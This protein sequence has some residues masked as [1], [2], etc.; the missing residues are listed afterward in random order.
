MRTLQ[1]E[2]YAKINLGLRVLSKRPDGYHEIDTVLQSVD[3][4]DLLTLWARPDGKVVLEMEPELGIP[5][6][7]NLAYRAAQSLKGRAGLAQG[8]RIRIE[9]RVPAGAG[10][11]GGSSDAAAVLAGLNAL[12]ALGLSVHELMALGAGLGSDVPFFLL[13]GR[14]RARGR[15]ERLEKLPDAAVEREMY[16]LLVP[17]FALG[18][19]EVYQTFDQLHPSQALSSPYP[20]DLEAAALALRPELKIYRRFLQ[21]QGVPFGMSGSGPTYF[22][23]LPSEAQA[24]ALAER[25]KRE[26]PTGTQAFVCRSTRVGYAWRGP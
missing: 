13:G 26:L 14:C 1:I 4:C 17:P 5:P 21:Q 24:Q 19:R 9:K 25:A 10:L 8:V 18:A 2:A 12:F 11:G 23:V 16:V 22:A 6:E 20:N 3:L 7:A 15:G